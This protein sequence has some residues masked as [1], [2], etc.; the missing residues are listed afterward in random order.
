M[1]IPTR[2]LGDVERLKVVVN[3]PLAELIELVLVA[4]EKALGDRLAGRQRT[5][6]KGVGSTSAV[7]LVRVAAQVQQLLENEHDDSRSLKVSAPELS[8]LVDVQKRQRFRWCQKKV[9]TH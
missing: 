2:G 3:D 9:L 6:G 1:A 5:A 4:G 8:M 7:N